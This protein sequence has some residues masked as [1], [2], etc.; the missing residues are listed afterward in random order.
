MDGRVL[1]PE[2]PESQQNSPD[3][4]QILTLLGMLAPMLGMVKF[5][6]GP[7]RPNAREALSQAGSQAAFFHGGSQPPKNSAT[8]KRSPE[9]LD[10]QMLTKQKDAMSELERAMLEE[11]NFSSNDILSP[12]DRVQAQDR[13]GGNAAFDTRDF[14]PTGL[15]ETGQ[16]LVGRE[17]RHRVSQEDPTELQQLIRVLTSKYR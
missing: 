9:M 13:L 10:P 6:L 17:L 14:D 12:L 1:M 11:R 16:G 8:W 3:A 7:K 15:G 4:L 5:P 2:Q